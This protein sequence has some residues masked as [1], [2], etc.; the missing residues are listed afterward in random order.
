M[1]NETLTARRRTNPFTTRHTRPGRLPPLDESGRPR[2]L[3]A[4]LAAVRRSPAT[5]IVGPHGTGKSTLLAAV[6][7]EL[8]AAGQAAD[9]R[10]LRR[11]RDGLALLATV[12]LTRQGQALCVDGWERLGAI[13]AA[14]VRLAAGIRGCQLVVTSHHP[15]GMPTIVRTAGTLPLLAAIVA[16]LPDHDGLIT[17]SDLA[18][19]FARH[20]GNLR[21]S[22]GDLYDRFELRVRRS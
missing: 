1:P 19:S 18:E 4:V 7:A 5:A 13:G 9:L 6:H 16:R 11:R 10:Q 17:G 22:L 15:T 20:G 12:L 14:T 3:G 8:E 21:D 2:D